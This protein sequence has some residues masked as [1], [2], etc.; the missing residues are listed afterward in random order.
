MNYSNSFYQALTTPN[1]YFYFC[2]KLHLVIFNTH[3]SRNKSS[4]NKEE[5]GLSSML[6]LTSKEGQSEISF[7]L[8]HQ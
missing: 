2:W 8:I 6:L 5:K 7:K 1:F 4:E 3:I